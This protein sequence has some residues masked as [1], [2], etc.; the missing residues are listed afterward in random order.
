MSRTS[1]VASTTTSASPG[2]KRSAT[3][4]RHGDQAVAAAQELRA[5]GQRGSWVVFDMA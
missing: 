5:L 3:L 2:R 1:L 4:V